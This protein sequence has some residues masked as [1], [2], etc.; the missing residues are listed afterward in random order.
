MKANLAVS[1]ILLLVRTPA[2]AHRLDEY[3]Q[4][5]L[6]SIEK[7]HVQAEMRL[8]PGVAV[9][10]IVLS[11]IDTDADGVLSEKEQRAYAERV[12]RDLSLT[13]DSQPLRLKLVSV[14]F[15]AA[16]DMKEGLGEIRLLLDADLSPGGR[17][18][19]LI[20]QNHHQGLIGAYLVNCL[21]PSDPDIR[22]TAQARN[23]DQSFYRLD[24]VE[25]GVSWL[26]AGREL[27]AAAVFLLFARIALTKW[28]PALRSR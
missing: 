15:P 16:E 18:R 21:V 23:F 28:L 7:K 24:Y 13:M 2:G 26:A 9:F 17:H 5:T 10:P 3:L 8:V 11:Q 14:K 25:A 27:L 20:F 22:V 12:L 19:R 4:A 6:F 1:A